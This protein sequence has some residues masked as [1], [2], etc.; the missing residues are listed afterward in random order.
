MRSRTTPLV[1]VLCLL[2][3]GVQSVAAWQR[4]LTSAGPVSQD[5]AQA[6]VIDSA[7]NVIV[8][9]TFWP[10]FR[11]RSR[12]VVLKLSSVGGSQMWRRRIKGMP[13][14]D[15]EV[16]VL[17][18]DSQ[19]D[20]IAGGRSSELFTVTKLDGAKGRQLWRRT[21]GGEAGLFGYNEAAA[22]VVDRNDDVIAGG[23]VGN[24]NAPGDYGDFA[25]VR[26]SS[27]TGEEVWR[28]ILR[29]PRCGESAVAVALDGAGDVLAAG[30]VP[31]DGAGC[32]SDADVLKLSG[33]DGEERWRYDLGGPPGPSGGDGDQARALAVDGAG[34][35][36]IAGWVH[37]GPSPGTPLVIGKLAG[38]SGSELW[39]VV[40]ESDGF[41]DAATLEVDPNGDVILG[42]G[43]AIAGGE[44]L[45]REVVVFKLARDDGRA[46]WRQTISDAAL[47]AMTLDAAGDILVAGALGGPEGPESDLGV[48]KLS[49]ITGE[50]R[51]SKLVDGSASG[52]GCSGESICGPVDRDT[53]FAVAVDSA[54]GI[55]TAGQLVQ[56]V[57]APTYGRRSHTDFAV[58]KFRDR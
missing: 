31:I 33:A 10:S 24:S 54:G 43:I 17:A 40:V 25:V 58:V 15:S 42:G 16:R 34:D 46:L 29:G 41:P 7:G 32:D 47:A 48:V 3:D 4:T 35:V 22:V 6:L 37:D 56:R 5:L 57:H 27:A 12:G 52:I 14:V 49:G 26:L 51:W 45:R 9:G 23:S 13:Y 19:E 20:I 8:G 11:K 55:V 2:S 36:I 28:H 30:N 39:R 38:G 18:L 21:L 1:L 50:P 53:A 44:T